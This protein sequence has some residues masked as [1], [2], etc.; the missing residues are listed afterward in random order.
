MYALHI[1]GGFELQFAADVRAAHLR[2]F[3]FEYLADVTFK[4]L[5]KLELTI[6]VYS[7]AEWSLRLGAN[8]ASTCT[9]L[10]IPI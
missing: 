4:H 9:S 1:C 10:S 5:L 8:N 3:I 6:H 7:V 2:S